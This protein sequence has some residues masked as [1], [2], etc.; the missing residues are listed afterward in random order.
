MTSQ[1]MIVADIGGTNIRIALANHQPCTQAFSY[2]LEVET[3]AYKSLSQVIDYYLR[4]YLH[5]QGAGGIVNTISKARIAVAGP[6]IPGDFMLTNTPFLVNTNELL[7]RSPI[8]DIQVVNDFEAQAMAL[9]YLSKED[10]YTLQKGHLNPQ[11]NI[12]VLGPGTG[13]G[14]AFLTYDEGTGYRVHPTEAGHTS[15]SPYDEITFGLHQFLSTRYDHVSNERLCSGQG[16]ENIYEYLSGQRL[17]AQAIGQA[18]IYDEDTQSLKTIHLFFE[19]LGHFAGNTA[20]QHQASGGVYISGGVF[21]KLQDTL[22]LKAFLHRF[23]HKGRLRPFLESTPL[24]HV[25][26]A[27]P[28]LFGLALWGSNHLNR[29]A[30]VV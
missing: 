2:L 11:G 9:P 17:E 16:L 14:V 24:Y 8:Q 5:T 20:L 3:K 23:N 4:V 18:A 6:P 22:D 30:A 21:T 25:D 15:F 7:K 26:R 10:K 29:T 27:H 13:L 12:S 1:Q 19:I 28:A